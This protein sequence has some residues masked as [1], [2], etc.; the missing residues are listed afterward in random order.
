MKRDNDNLPSDIAFSLEYL[1]TGG[2][3]EVIGFA[4]LAY[5]MKDPKVQMDTSMAVALCVLAAA[6]LSPEKP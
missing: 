1:K 3:G 5:E 4:D 6:A 2:L